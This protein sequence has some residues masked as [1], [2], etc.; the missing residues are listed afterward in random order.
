MTFKLSQRSLEQTAG[1]R[2]TTGRDGKTGNSG[3]KDRLRCDLRFAH[4]GGATG[5]C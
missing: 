2:R 1:R 3:H 4:D 5:S